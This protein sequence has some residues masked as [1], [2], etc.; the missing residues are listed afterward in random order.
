MLPIEK[1]GLFYV[2]P[3][4][5]LN[6][7]PI[8]FHMTFCFKF[9]GLDP[10]FQY[11]IRLRRLLYCPLSCSYYILEDCFV[12]IS[13]IC[14]IILSQIPYLIHSGYLLCYECSNTILQVER[15]WLVLHF[16]LGDVPYS[17]VFYTHEYP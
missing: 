13:L 8:I 16:F 6:R 3:Q 12:H 11:L 10:Q 5:L 15:Y 1:L 14:K 2:H 4:E 7:F 17:S 9:L